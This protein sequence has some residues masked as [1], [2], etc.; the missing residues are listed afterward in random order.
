M[1]LRAY[2]LCLLYLPVVGYHMPDR[3]G[4]AHH[5]KTGRFSKHNGPPLS[6]HWISS[7]RHHCDTLHRCQALPL[8]RCNPPR[9]LERLELNV[10]GPGQ[11]NPYRTQPHHGH[12]ALHG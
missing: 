2:P 8:L 12:A 7:E 5:M 4:R 3:V 1:K 11:I 10:T 6:H 9:I